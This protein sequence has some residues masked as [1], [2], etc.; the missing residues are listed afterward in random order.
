MATIR[1]MVLLTVTLTVALCG[2]AQADTL[3]TSFAVAN[4]GQR[5]DCVVTNVGTTPITVTVTLTN[6][7]GTTITPSLDLCNGI[8]LGPGKTCQV[9]PATDTDAF[10]TVVSSSSKV[11]AAIIVFGPLGSGRPTVTVFPATK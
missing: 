4:A 8:P 9:L 3:Q 7:F 2:T 6:L 1:I 11:R 5:L 10:C